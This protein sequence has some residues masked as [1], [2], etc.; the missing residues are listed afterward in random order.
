LQQAEAQLA[1]TLA[2]DSDVKRM[3]ADQ[4]HAL[5][6][7]CGQPAAS[8]NV[9]VEPL[10]QQKPP[11]IPAGLP[12]TLLRRRPD[13]AAAEQRVVAANAQVG[14]AL[15][16]LLPRFDLSGWAGFEST[17]LHS[18]FAWAS[19]LGSLVTGITAPLFDGGRLRAASRAA[20][21]RFRQAVAAYVQQ[22]LIAYSD[23]EDALTDLAAWQTQVEHLTRAVQASEDYRRLA[24]VQYNSGLVD[25]LTVIDAERTLLSNQLSL[26]EATSSRASASI[27]LIK[28]L[29]GGVLDTKPR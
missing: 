3:R 16:D 11:E 6:V 28:A 14:V 18:L 29:G 22:V 13:V 21:A 4:E 9:P 25:Y 27:H 12:A 5:A 26:A 24:D 1:A 8:F 20:R 10:A 17:S 15:A 19:R 23:T 7:L 2:Q